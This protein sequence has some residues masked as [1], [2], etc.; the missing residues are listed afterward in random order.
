[1]WTSSSEDL[2]NGTGRRF[3]ISSSGRRLTFADVL[4]LWANDSGFRS[5]YIDVLS[6]AP[7]SAFRWETPPV[8]EPTL[9][10]E[11]EF[12]L[13]DCPAL[14]RSPDVAAFAAHF[15]DERADDKVVT[16]ANLGRDAVL[17]VPSPSGTMDSYAHLAAFIRKAPV[18]Q[19]HSLWIA[20][21][22]AM[23]SRVS[24]QPVWLSTAGMGVAWL[25][26]RLDDRPKYYGHKPYKQA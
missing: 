22:N 24:Q 1:M 13:L 11:F 8:S 3:T 10:R 5:F 15:G 7:Y 26:V 19:R 9:I 25:H 12:V 14:E 17:V 20:V 23:R 18:A 21:S 16:F 4:T 2:V 6:S